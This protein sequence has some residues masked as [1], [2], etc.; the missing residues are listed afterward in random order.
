MPVTVDAA[1][2]GALVPHTAP[3]TRARI[4]AAI[5]DVAHLPA[6]VLTGLVPHAPGVLVASDL[7]ATTSLGSTPAGDPFS[8]QHTFKCTCAKHET[9]RST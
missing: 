9:Q 8:N 1:G 6:L 5:L 7:I 2:A 4:L 3:V